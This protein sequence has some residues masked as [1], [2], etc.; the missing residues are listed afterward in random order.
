MTEL[1][2]TPALTSLQCDTTSSVSASSGKPSFTRRRYRSFVSDD[3]RYIEE[4]S[5]LPNTADYDTSAICGDGSLSAERCAE[6]PPS[7][8]HTSKSSTSED[9]LTF[10]EEVNFVIGEGDV[11]ANVTGQA[12]STSKIDIM[13]RGIHSANKQSFAP[14]NRTADA[15][16]DG[17][18]EEASDIVRLAVNDAMRQ[19]HQPVLATTSNQCNEFLVSSGCSDKIQPTCDKE[20]EHPAEVSETERCEQLIRFNSRH[21]TKL[22]FHEAVG[23]NSPYFDEVDRFSAIKG[24]PTTTTPYDRV[25]PIQLTSYSC[26]VL[27]PSTRVQAERFERIVKTKCPRSVILSMPESLMCRQTEA[28]EW[29]LAA[30]E[31]DAPV[32]VVMGSEGHEEEEKPSSVLNDDAEL[33]EK[34]EKEATNVEA[35]WLYAQ[36]WADKETF[37]SQVERSACQ[38]AELMMVDEPVSTQTIRLMHE[39]R[40]IKLQTDHEE[41]PNVGD[42]TCRGDGRPVHAADTDGEQPCDENYSRAC[43]KD[44]DQIS[45]KQYS[46]TSSYNNG[47]EGEFQLN[48]EQQKEEEQ[49]RRIPAEVAHVKPNSRDLLQEQHIIMEERSPVITDESSLQELINSQQEKI[50]DDEL[51]TDSRFVKPNVSK[52]LAARDDVC[53]DDE[54]DTNELQTRLGMGSNSIADDDNDHDGDEQLHNIRRSATGTITEPGV[55]GRSNPEADDLNDVTSNKPVVTIV[56]T[57]C[58]AS[59]LPLG[60]A[61]SA[62]DDTA[63]AIDNQVVKNDD[64]EGEIATESDLVIKQPLSPTDASINACQSRQLS[65]NEVFEEIDSSPSSA[66]NR[67]TDLWA[68]PYK[69]T[70][71]CS[72]DDFP[73]VDNPQ[74]DSCSVQSPTVERPNFFTENQPQQHIND[75]SPER[76]SN[77]SGDVQHDLAVDPSIENSDSSEPYVVETSSLSV[78][79]LDQHT[80]LNIDQEKTTVE[81]ASPPHVAVEPV[82]THSSCKSSGSSGDSDT[83]YESQPYHQLENDDLSDGLNTEQE[84][85]SERHRTAPENIL[86]CN[87]ETDAITETG[88]LDQDQIQRDLSTGYASTYTDTV[89]KSEHSDVSVAS[90]VEDKHKDEM[91]ELFTK[92]ET[93][94]KPNFVAQDSVN[95]KTSHGFL[96]FPNQRVSSNVTNVIEKH[97]VSKLAVQTEVDFNEETVPVNLEDDPVS[98]VAAEIC[99]LAADRAVKEWNQQQTTSALHG[100]LKCDSCTQ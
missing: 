58:D 85:A 52:E 87:G 70:S 68:T 49:M 9:G 78:S 20:F 29:K 30:A 64:V 56:L 34:E 26:D 100:E 90:G 89:N 77:E 51:A 37:D 86:F 46:S 62:A 72:T 50:N 83:S 59:Y 53:G 74:S 4:V 38:K 73:N 57:E 28:E 18:F 24:Q 17:L 88:I 63:A 36:R 13:D 31:D 27:E 60:M 2:V 12:V 5:F 25:V 41:L 16:D 15:G 8:R 21:S 44:M 10:I 80:P 97:C 35:L 82:L 65:A 67:F 40:S 84:V 39:T 61:T 43:A 19:F 3:G 79:K 92:E 22:R 54:Q 45:P 33:N 55:T 69:S 14:I 81:T 76:L 98:E 42:F 7:C 11:A 95:T 48:Q 99:R 66:S 96:I 23:P 71:T 6:R 93:L 47:T 91:T 32:S 75:Q 1:S 94:A